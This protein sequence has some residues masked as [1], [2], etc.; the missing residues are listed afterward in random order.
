MKPSKTGFEPKL[1]QD[2]QVF[3]GFAN[4]YYCFIQEFNKIVALLTSI[5][6]TKA[7]IDVGNKLSKSKL[8]FLTSDTKKAFFKL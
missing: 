8:G 4:F 2:I 7:T 3:I 6:K 5:L 1:A